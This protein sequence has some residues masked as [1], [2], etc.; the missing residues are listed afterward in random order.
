M[1]QRRA[2][3][4]AEHLSFT[5]RAPVLQLSAPVWMIGGS[6]GADGEQSR[7]PNNKPGEKSPVLWGYPGGAASP[8]LPAGLSC[9]PF[10]KHGEERA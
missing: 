3:T 6:L 5:H 10:A 7:A 9:P 2:H 1:G 8:K 4:R